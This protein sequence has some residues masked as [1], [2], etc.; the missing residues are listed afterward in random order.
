MTHKKVLLPV[1]PFGDENA[2]G[3]SCLTGLSL[4]YLHFTAIEYFP[5][6]A[7]GESV[8][9]KRWDFLFRPSSMVS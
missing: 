2:M 8:R 9:E 5:K 6:G 7:K 1:K 3:T 4:D